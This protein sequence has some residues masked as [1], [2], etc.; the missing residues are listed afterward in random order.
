MHKAGDDGFI[1]RYMSAAQWE[2]V[3]PASV[4]PSVEK[5]AGALIVNVS[6][7]KKAQSWGC[8]RTLG[9]HEDRRGLL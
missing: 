3:S 9:L 5:A 7:A 4:M 6:Y 8:G 2:I 1:A